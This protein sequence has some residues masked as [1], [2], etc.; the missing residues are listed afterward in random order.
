M[1]A[2]ALGALA[3]L[4]LTASLDAAE[5]SRFPAWPKPEAQ[6]MRPPEQPPENGPRL[7]QESVESAD[8]GVGTLSEKDIEKLVEKKLKERE[9]KK[10]KDEE[11]K[12]EEKKEED[13]AKRA[14]DL[15]GDTKFE[16]QT[17][18]DSLTMPNLDGDKKW[19]EKLSIRGYTQFRFSRALSQDLDGADPILFGDRS[20]N[21]E[22]E[23]FSIRRA[24]LIIF[25]DVSDYLYVY[26]QPDFASTPQGSTVSTFFGQLRDLYADVYLEKTKEHRL[27]VGLSK[28]PYAFENMQSSQNRLPLDRTDAM[29]SAVA[30]NERDLGV[31]YYWTPPDYQKLFKTLVDSGLKGS[32]NY[33]LV[34][35]GGYNG[36]GGSVFEA[37]LNLHT[38][39]RVTYPLQFKNG[40]VVEGSVQG[41]T[42][43]Y[44]VQGAPILLPDSTRL[45]T[46]KGTGRGTD[47]LDQRVAG[48]FVW[49]PQPIGFQA[50]WECGRGPGLNPEQTEVVR[51]SLYGGYV[52]AMYRYDSHGCGLF[53]PYCRYQQYTGGYRSFANAPYGHQ[54]Q[55][56]VGLEWQIRREMELVVEYT[57]VNTPN[58][59]ARTTSASYEDFDGTVLRCQFQINY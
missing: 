49:Y 47:I 12:K 7:P 18:Y 40:Q 43:E 14:F 36:Q 38:V 59:T 45:A 8:Q 53:T 9:E 58:F 50:E 10:K 4:V 31:F 16:L 29:N 44:T 20:V 52:M 27:R 22:A 15:F 2:L 55:L 56:D 11:E 51:R 30:P 28:V 1:I 24:R 46:P 39:G 13:R 42:G 19:Y 21:G 26:I 32:G 3:Y 41:Y 54:R 5:P 6:P 37:N 17:L 25:G 34:G 35:F 33:G 57:V 48:T 23:N